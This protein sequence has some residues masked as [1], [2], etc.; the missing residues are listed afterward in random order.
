MVGIFV[1]LGPEFEGYDGVI[2]VA[3]G[4]LKIPHCQGLIVQA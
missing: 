3:I 2:V 1:L 4:V